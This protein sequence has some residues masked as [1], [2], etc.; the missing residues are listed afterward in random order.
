M[1]VT[2]PLF[3]VTVGRRR[4]HR[5]NGYP[6]S[7]THLT[8]TSNMTNRQLAQLPSIG[9]CRTSGPRNRIGRTEYI[10]PMVGLPANTTTSRINAHAEFSPHRRTPRD[11]LR[12]TAVARRTTGDHR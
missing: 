2:P 5:A 10:R 7:A 12:L 11:R 1:L 6:P 8:A 9:I 3:N 4:G